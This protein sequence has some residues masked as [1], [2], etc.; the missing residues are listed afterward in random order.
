M[1]VSPTFLFQ[2]LAGGVLPSVRLDPSPAR[3]N[4]LGLVYLVGFAA[5]AIGLRRLRATGRGRGAAALFAVQAVGLT[6]AACQQLQDLTGTRPLGDAF[7]GACDV[8]W[9]LSHM[10]M[11]VV[12]AA[13]WRAGVWTG[14]RRWTPLACGLVLPAMFAAVA[15]AGR[16][17]MG[18][19]FPPGTAAAFF[20]LGLAVFTAPATGAEAGTR[21]RL[22]VT[23]LS[24]RRRAG[25]TPSRAPGPVVGPPRRT[26]PVAPDPPTPSATP[27]P[28]LPDAASAA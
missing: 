10:L 27:V 5:S 24:E 7:Y 22:T 4:L 23:R 20:A 19:V 6:L 2:W 18:F 13:V 9:P 8:A 25:A 11:L 15:V 12:F 3:D 26:P 1:L 28:P 17:A 16:G 14:W 21:G